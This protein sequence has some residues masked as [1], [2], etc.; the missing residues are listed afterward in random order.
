MKQL[1]VTT[2]TNFKDPTLL[3]TAKVN[4]SIALIKE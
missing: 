4:K 2:L 3:A 1:E